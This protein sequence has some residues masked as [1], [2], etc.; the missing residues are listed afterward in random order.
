M[1]AVEAI[2]SMGGLSTSES[3]KP[4]HTTI[5]PNVAAA[6]I[7]FIPCLLFFFLKLWIVLLVYDF[8][9]IFILVSG[10]SNLKWKDEINKD[11]D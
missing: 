7:F 3:N 4:N 9:I 10:I 1:A 5:L 11:T 8:I 2:T 6:I